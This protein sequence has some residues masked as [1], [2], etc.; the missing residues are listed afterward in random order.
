MTIKHLYP[1][2][3]P[4]LDLNFAQTKRLDPRV[5]FTRASTATY[6][7]SDGLIK[8]AASDEARFDHDPATGESL[9]L[10]VEESR[11]NSVLNSNTGNPVFPESGV[12]HST[13]GVG[14]DGITSAT[15]VVISSTQGT[16]GLRWDGWSTSSTETRSFFVK[17]LSGSG[18]TITGQGGSGDSYT[19][20]ISTKTYSSDSRHPTGGVDDYGNGWY[21]CWQGPTGVGG[22]VGTYMVPVDVG[23]Y[24]FWGFQRETGSFPTSYIP[25][26]G[27]TATRAADVASM[28]G[29]NFS[30]WYNQNE[31]TVFVETE[32][33]TLTNTVAVSIS[34][35]TTQNSIELRS[36]G[37]TADTV[38][39]TIFKSGLL[40]NDEF[41][42]DTAYKR[43]IF[44][45]AENNSHAVA[46]GILRT[47]DASVSIPTV[48]NLYFG[49][50]L[51]LQTQRPGH[52]KRFTY[53]DRRLTDTQ[54]Q[55]LTL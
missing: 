11:T 31:G 53:Y 45:Y 35:G 9:G 12:S 47:T 38:R 23:T 13:S 54:L 30:S 33:P 44:A 5:T 42:A 19:W 28:T 34:D 24:L 49:N 17:V 25:T 37:S 16:T 52:I 18:V 50:N 32:K 48:D 51:F 21:R 7:G 14:L 40:F 15:E 2:T 55:A 1:V 27:T 10:L 43:L 4:S 3:R 6:V 29:T 36:S 39:F 46:N 8:T 41:T 20:N 26:A 22:G